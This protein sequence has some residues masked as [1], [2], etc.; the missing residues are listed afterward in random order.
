VSAQGPL[1]EQG[2]TLDH[3][4]VAAFDVLPGFDQGDLH[5]ALAHAGVAHMLVLRDDGAALVVLPGDAPAVEALRGATH[6]ARIGV[7]DVLGRPDRV[8]DAAREARWAHTAATMLDERLVRYGVT[9]PLFLPRTIGEAELAAARVLGSLLAYDDEHGTDLLH[10]LAVFLANNR[11]WQ[12]TASLL[13]VHK[14]TLVYR[15]RRIEGLTG[16]RLNHT[17]DVAELWLALQAHDVA[18][19]VLTAGPV[20]S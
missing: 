16:R 9:T 17:A 4:V 15:M 13:H 6:G 10:S 8:P 2:L 3:D 11:S 19:G 5:H 12:R 18:R 20:G 1:A 7:S 14:Q